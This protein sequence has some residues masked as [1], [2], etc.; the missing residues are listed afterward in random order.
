M[1]ESSDTLPEWLPT[2]SLTMSLTFILYAKSIR[3]ISKHLIFNNL[4]FFYRVEW[5]YTTLLRWV[6]SWDYHLNAIRSKLSSANFAISKIKHIVPE[7]VKLYYQI[8]SY[9]IKSNQIKSYQIISNH[10]KS[11][12]IKS[13][14]LFQRK[15]A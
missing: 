12:Q 13:N 1:H 7:K 5:Q 3:I 15:Q 2:K 10:I 11:Y 4:T 9:Q 14:H 6:L 8:K